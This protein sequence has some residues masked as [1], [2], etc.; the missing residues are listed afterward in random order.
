[1]VAELLEKLVALKTGRLVAETEESHARLKVAD[2]AYVSRVELLLDDNSLRTLYVGSS[3]SYGAGH[4]RVAEQDEVYL[5]TDLSSTDVS[6]QLSSWIDT[7]YLS[8]NAQ[9]FVSAKLENQNGSFEFFKD[10]D[11]WTM[12]GLEEGET[13]S[14]SNI[15]SLVSRA[16]SVRMVRPL[17]TESKPSY[18]LQAPN[19]VLVIRAQSAEG[20]ESTYTVYVGAQRLEDGSYVLK[21][22]E[23]PYYVRVAEYTAQDWVEKTREDFLEQADTE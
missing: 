22:S 1:V 21:A 14:S 8:L 15:S 9:E 7:S 13:A 20:T 19:A 10:G 11:E 23:S 6:T 5:V 12:D 2:D 3:P 17:G 18:G 16:A 4:V